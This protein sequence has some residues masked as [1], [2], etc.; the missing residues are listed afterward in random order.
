[1][2]WTSL[3]ITGP[4]AVQVLHQRRELEDLEEETRR[5]D[6]GDLRWILNIGIADSGGQTLVCSLRIHGAG[7]FTYIGIILNYFRGQCR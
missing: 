7:I 2:G 4:P 3:D 6:F 5:H 1:M